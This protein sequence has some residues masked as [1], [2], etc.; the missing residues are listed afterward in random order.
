MRASNFYS[1]DTEL[2]TKKEIAKRLKVCTRQ[3]EVLANNGTIPVIRFG[4]LVRYKWQDVLS[5]LENTEGEAS[6]SISNIEG[7]Q[8]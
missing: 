4:R 3:V 1:V 6:Y 5:A 2:I 7:G 8:V